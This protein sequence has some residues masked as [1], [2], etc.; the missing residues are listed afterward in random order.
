MPRRV[1][2]PEPVA[3]APVE[4]LAL[5]DEGA[6]STNEAAKFIGESRRTIY[7]MMRAGVISYI[8]RGKFRRIPKRVLIAYLASFPV[9]NGA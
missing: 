2:T 9:V 1:P 6:L 3:P 8:Q 7:R 4:N 5:F